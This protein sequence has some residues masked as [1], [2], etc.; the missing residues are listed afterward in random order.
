VVPNEMGI[1]DR[2]QFLFGKLPGGHGYSQVKSKPGYRHSWFS[3]PK[4]FETFII[5]QFKAFSY[6]VR[7]D[8][9]FIGF[10][11]NRKLSLK[12]WFWWIMALFLPSSLMASERLFLLEFE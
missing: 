6:I 12:R 7:E 8:C 4:Q 2:I 10:Q 9:W 3:D 11:N 1:R 5:S